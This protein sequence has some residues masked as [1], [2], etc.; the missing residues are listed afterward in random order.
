[1]DY[2]KNKNFKK[3]WIHTFADENN[4]EVNLIDIYRSKGLLN[5]GKEKEDLADTPIQVTDNQPLERG[6]ANA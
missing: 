3:G 2:D 6:I 1:M 5:L 4:V